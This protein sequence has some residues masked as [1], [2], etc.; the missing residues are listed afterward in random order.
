MAATVIEK[1]FI[2]GIPLRLGREFFGSKRLDRKRVNREG[3]EV[4]DFT[5]DPL[6]AL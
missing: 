1:R 2:V 4:G 6:M 5:Q 3:N